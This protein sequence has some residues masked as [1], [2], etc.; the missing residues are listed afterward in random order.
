INEIQK[1]LKDIGIETIFLNTDMDYD[2][3]KKDDE[4]V[5]FFTGFAFAV[6]D[7][8]RNFG[9]F[10]KG[11]YFTYEQPNDYKFERL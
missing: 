2:K 6:K 11:S 10:R 1:Q 7:P 4:N 5:L 9:H 3:F 8:N